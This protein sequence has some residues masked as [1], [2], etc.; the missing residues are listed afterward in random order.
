MRML[1][2]NRPALPVRGLPVTTNL[3]VEFEHVWPAPVDRIVLAEAP[4]G[5]LL[6]MYVVGSRFLE[7]RVV[8]RLRAVSGMP[9]EFERFQDEVAE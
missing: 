1:P 2:P 7:G 9:T 6:E 4:S 3:D 5:R 8:L